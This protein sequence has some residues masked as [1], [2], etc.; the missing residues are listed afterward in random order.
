[1]TGILMREKRRFETQTHKREGHEKVE[2]EIGVICLK[3]RNTKNFW[4]LPEART[5]V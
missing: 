3:L 5:Q 4:Q 1:M 2:T